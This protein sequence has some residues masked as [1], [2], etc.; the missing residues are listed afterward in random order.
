MLRWGHLIASFPN[1]GFLGLPFLTRL[2]GL[3]A[4]VPIM[5][6]I[7]ID[8]VMTSSICI[9]MAHFDRTGG[10]SPHDAIKRQVSQVLKNPLPWAIL[11]GV[12]HAYFQIEFL[13]GIQKVL[14]LLSDAAS[15]LALFALGGVLARTSPDQKGASSLNHWS[16]VVI[17]L[18]IHPQFSLWAYTSSQALRLVYHQLTNIF[19]PWCLFWLAGYPVQA[20]SSCFQKSSGANGH[21]LSKVILTTTV[22]S[23]LTLPVLSALIQ[24]HLK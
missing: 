21:R 5:I 9:F 3:S 7:F 1:T 18:V 6:S 12:S 22:L 2:F 13:P 19:G 24:G 14:E 4:A 11:L 23:M 8:M 17:K 10:V 16:L 15:P 20:M